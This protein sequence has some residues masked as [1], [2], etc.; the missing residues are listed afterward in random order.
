MSAEGLSAMITLAIRGIDNG[1]AQYLSMRLRNAIV[2]GWIE[3]ETNDPPAN[4]SAAVFLKSK[5][6]DASVIAECL[7]EGVHVLLSGASHLSVHDFI[8]LCAAA[9]KSGALFSV[10]NLDRYL[11]SR[12]LIHDQLRSGQ[13]GEP[14]LIRSHRWEARALETDAELNLPHSLIRDL[15]LTTWLFGMSPDVVYAVEQSS[16]SSTREPIKH[17]DLRPPRRLT[18]VHLGFTGGGMAL[19][20]YSNGLPDGAGYQMLSVIGSAGVSHVD[21]HRNLQL[22]FS[23]GEPRGIRSSERAHGLARLIQEFVD[24]LTSGSNPWPGNSAW[25]RSMQL[26]AAVR[27]SLDSRSALTLKDL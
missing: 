3:R 16:G 2:L 6:S 12:Q 9:E 19:I 11:P 17:V 8:Q 1:D 4:C 18:Q 10:V 5:S 24:H 20:D 14:G 15:E 26:A 21:D 13:L 7:T 22:H 27:R 23:G 25:E